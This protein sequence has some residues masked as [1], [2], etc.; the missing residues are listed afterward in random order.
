MII[1][2]SVV[3]VIDVIVRIVIVMTLSQLREQ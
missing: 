1:G 2:M 3:V